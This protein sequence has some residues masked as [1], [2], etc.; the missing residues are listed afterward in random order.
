M[1]GSN[2]GGGCGRRTEVVGGLGWNCSSRRR[3]R[4]TAE[5]DARTTSAAS[6]L[7]TPP[8][9]ITKT[10]TSTKR[11]HTFTIVQRSCAWWLRSKLR[12]QPQVK[13]STRRGER[14]GVKGGEG[15]FDPS[16]AAAQSTPAWRG[17]SPGT[18]GNH[19]DLTRTPARS[20]T[21]HVV[22]SFIASTRAPCYPRRR[23]CRVRQRCAPVPP[24]GGADPSRPRMPLLSPAPSVDRARWRQPPHRPYL[25]S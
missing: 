23:Q 8:T 24:Q 5:R 17:N 19:S 15:Q 14:K 4:S 2:A 21:W 13:E 25:P 20:H 12:T 18:T 10:S 6:S 1:I 3:N 7:S 9:P 16:T 22:R 11:E